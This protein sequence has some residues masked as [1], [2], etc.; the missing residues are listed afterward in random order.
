MQEEIL[1]MGKT[2]EMLGISK[3]SVRNWI[4]HGYLQAVDPK[5]NTFYASEALKLKRAVMEGKIDRLNKRANKVSAG[6][7]FMPTEYIKNEDHRR[8]LSYLIDYIN[9]SKIE[10]R[11]AILILALNLFRVNGDLKTSDLSQLIPFKPEVF[12]RKSV[13]AEMQE[14]WAQITGKERRVKVEKEREKGNELEF[15]FN[16]P[17]PPERDVL[18]IVYQ[19]LMKEGKKASLGSYFTPAALVERMVRENIHPGQKVLD[20]CCGTGQFLLA[21]SDYPQE[22]DSIFGIDI[23]QTAVR[24]ARFNLLLRFP[25]DFTPKIFHLNTLQDVDYKNEEADSLFSL[26]EQEEQDKNGSLQSADYD[27]IATNPPWGA[28]IAPNTLKK[29]RREFPDITSGEAFSFFL[30]LSIL[31]LKEGGVLSFVLPEAILNIRSHSDI[32]KY[33]LDNCQI[34]RIECL[35]KKFK[36]VLSSVIR[37]DL[38][39]KKPEGQEEI[40]VRR[41][42]EEYRIA[43]H[44]FLRNKWYVFDV[45]L[46]GQDEQILRKVFQTEHTTLE[47]K[48]E[49][50]LG[51]VTGDNR[52]FLRDKPE[53]GCEP[54]YKGSDVGVFSLKKANTYIKFAP[55]LFQ[56]VA[57]EEKYRAKEKLV[58]RFISCAPVFAYDDKGSLTLNSANILIPKFNYPL[59]VILAL[60]NSSLYGFIYVKKFNSLKILRGDLEQLP[61]PLWPEEVFQRVTEMVDGIRQGQEGLMAL[62]SYLME[63]FG[64]SPE[65]MHYVY[66]STKRTRHHG[67][68]NSRSDQENGLGSQAQSLPE[69]YE[70]QRPTNRIR[71]CRGK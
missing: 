54:I 33:I 41:P 1:D 60:F 3:A 31:L 56:Q 45:Y 17:L 57:P 39:K 53:K 50:A 34:K 69:G 46:N 19:S 15:I 32:R 9:Q 68:I 25:Q 44:R 47:G 8:R 65:E 67:T 66:S 52:K 14:F 55:E 35:G 49:W 20:P 23:D 24:I 37:L 70:G 5:G 2:A 28:K 30:R 29:L 11:M 64:L 18:G 13:F 63:Q 16:Y 12:L 4:K 10:K 26:G 62:D 22:P 61:L 43:Q 71:K 6:K 38:I 27:L 21:C 42:G 48:A 51:I 59:K 7:C 58:Y 40:L 36:N